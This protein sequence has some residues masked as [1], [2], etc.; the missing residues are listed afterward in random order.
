[1]KPM[2]QP[3]PSGKPGAFF[4]AVLCVTFCTANVAAQE[5]PAPAPGKTAA[6]SPGA[7]GEVIITA[8]KQAEFDSETK[9]AV[10]LGNVKVVDPQFVIRCDKLTAYMAKSDEGGLERAVATGN[11]RVVQ[12]KKDPQGK[13]KRS[14]GDGDKMIWEAKS[15]VARLSGNARVQQGVN[16][17]IAENAET[18]MVITRDGELT[19]EGR[20]RTAFK[21]E[22]KKED[23]KEEQ[24]KPETSQ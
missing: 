2:N 17:H 1:M 21:T 4:A 8:D 6:P 5:S 22:E 9:T 3:G 16:L 7:S 18:V 10:F 14:V 24:D 13:A 15:G 20:S 23:K 12:E 11:V 19:T